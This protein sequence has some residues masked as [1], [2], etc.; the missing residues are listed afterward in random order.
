MLS[1]LAGQRSSGPAPVVVGPDDLV[2]EG[3]APEDPVQQD[4]A[5]VDLAVVDVEIQ[6]AVVGQ[7]PVRL[8]Q[9]RPEPA[10]VVVKAVGIGAAGAAAGLV[11]AAPEAGAVAVRRLARCH[12]R[13]GLLP[14]GV[15]GWVE[16]DQPIGAVSQGRQDLEAVAL[17]QPV[18]GAGHRV[19]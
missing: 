17:E 15:E 16:V 3:L 2:E 5:V 18:T 19:R 14:A 10:G 7:Q 13:Q 1:C 11:G 4:L 12:P 6:G 9:A 8:S